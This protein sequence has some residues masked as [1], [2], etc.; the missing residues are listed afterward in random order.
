MAPQN[1]NM[2]LLLT[3]EL[4]AGE[5]KF[6]LP[7]YSEV[8]KK[9]FDN[10]IFDKTKL[11][12]TNQYLDQGLYDEANRNSRRKKRFPNIR[13]MAIEPLT[14]IQAL[15]V[16]GSSAASCNEE[17]LSSSFL[18]L[19][20]FQTIS[21]GEITTGDSKA[22]NLSISNTMLKEA[23]ER[24]RSRLNTNFCVGKVSYEYRHADEEEE[25]KCMS[26]SSSDGE[27]ESSAAKCGSILSQTLEKVRLIMDN[28]K[29]PMSPDRHVPPN[30]RM[31]ADCLK[32]K[33]Y[34]EAS[35]VAFGILNAD[36][37][38]YGENDL[39][40]AIDYH[41]LGVTNALAGDLDTSLSYFQESIVLK[42]ACLGNNDS[43][44]A[45]SL[46]EIGILLY[47]KHD[48]EGA[49]NIFNEAFEIYINE[50]DS[51]SNSLDSIGRTSNN[52]GC[53]YY[54]M[55]DIASALV[56]MQKS[57]VAQRSALGL[58][59]KAESSLVNCAITQAN[60][61]YLKFESDHLDALTTLEES[62]LVLESVLGDENMTVESVR[63]N[64]TLAKQQQTFH[65]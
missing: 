60:S 7:S 65:P 38:R 5:R 39:V 44:V 52:I 17:T 46:V 45:D 51:T 10:I 40:C 56:Y 25:E 2:E 30:H 59:E 21:L 34:D 13:S 61:G 3:S 47:N 20:G 11:K 42:R 33:E 48:L 1:I 64:I 54:Q 19:D 29:E 57:L 31:V 18:I 22:N 6:V 27:Y 36:Q 9:E 32:F 15:L 55:G 50:N 26:F 23:T 41:N 53:V 49:L 63:S 12:A 16:P 14:M 58:S 62:L 28:D 8:L 4:A 35:E 24:W 37:D 43:I